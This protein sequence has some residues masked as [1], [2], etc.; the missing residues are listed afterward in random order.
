MV[1]EEIENEAFNRGLG[2]RLRLARRSRGW[3]LTEVEAISDGEFK[4]SVVGAYERGERSLTVHRMVRL[5]AVYG[6]PVDS[7]LPRPLD[8]PDTTI[9]LTSTERE[10]HGDGALIERYL[11]SIQMMRR[12]EAGELAI[13]SSDLRLLSLMMAEDRTRAP[14]LGDR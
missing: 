2:E 12:S 9:D 5:A 6:I 11:G 7:L 14:D 8:R 1:N 3:S 10:D 4:A 13:R